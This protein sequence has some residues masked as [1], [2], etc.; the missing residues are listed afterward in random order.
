MTAHIFT[1]KNLEEIFEQMD[2]AEAEAN[3]RVLPAQRAID[4]NERVFRAVSDGEGGAIAIWGKVWSQEEWQRREADA[5]ATEAELRSSLQVLL[6]SHDRGYRFGE[7]WSVVTP[8][9]EI[10]SAHISSLWPITVDDFEVAKRN[11][12]QIWPEFLAR[13]QGEVH[14][15]VHQAHQEP[16]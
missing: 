6:S 8:E 12:W 13:I 15:A 2:Q 5:G 16:T 11:E 7:Y 1:G 4:W 9:G 14:Q 10:G 3:E